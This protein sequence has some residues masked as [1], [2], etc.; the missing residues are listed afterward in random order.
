MSEIILYLCT[1]EQQLICI[2]NAKIMPDGDIVKVKV[3]N[4]YRNPCKIIMEDKQD[5]SKCKRFLL[6]ALKKEVQKRGNAPIEAIKNL[7]HILSKDYDSINSMES[8]VYEWM[9]KNLVD[10]DLSANTVGL[11]RRSVN[12]LTHE[13]RYE[14]IDSS[15]C[16]ASELYKKY[17]ISIHEHSFTSVIQSTPQKNL[18][19]PKEYLLSKISDLNCDM[20]HTIELWSNKLS[21]SLSV[22]KLRLPN[23]KRNKPTLE[24]NLL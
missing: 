12:V 20:N 8:T 11:L 5:N 19:L 7:S 1:I 16:M 10:Y 24:E 9:S 21:E 15:V 18:D 23:R 13:L 14:G 4:L 3:S 6:T 2:T 22:D 17:I